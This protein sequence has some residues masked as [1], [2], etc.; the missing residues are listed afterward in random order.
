LEE[1]NSSI[2]I[3]AH[4]DDEILWFSSILTTVDLIIIVFLTDPE[5]DLW[6]IGRIKTKE[7]YP[8]KNVK[9]LEIDEAG[10]PGN[11]SWIDPQIS[12]YG[13]KI[14]PNE[15]IKTP[16][17]NNYPKIKSALAPYLKKYKN[18]F[19]HNPWGEYGHV[20][21]CQIYKIISEFQNEF[22]FKIWFPNF[23]SNKSAKLFK[24][25]SSNIDRHFLSIETNKSLASQIKKIY[26]KNSCWTWYDDWEWLS[27]DIFLSLSFDKSNVD[28]YGYHI[29]LEMI[30]VGLPN[31]LES[32]PR[33]AVFNIIRIW[34]YAK[35]FLKN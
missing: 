2:L 1:T 20:E 6:T 23:I 10:T 3:V 30:K 13:I 33:K 26:A 25:Y 34:K 32:Q 22:G 21:H 16:Y 14:D 31:R 18:V 28:K 7:E 19:T 4:P 5:N 35:G 9:W 11:A 8:L 27:K 15:K 12:T 29:P 24:T 17:I